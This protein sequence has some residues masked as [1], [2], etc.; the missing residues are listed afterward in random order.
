MHPYV[1]ERTEL[2]RNTQYP[3]SVV[4]WA[5]HAAGDP[6]T[7][8]EFAGCAAMPPVTSFANAHPVLFCLTQLC[9]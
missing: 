1:R 8:R 2:P 6:D 3:P 4:S 5:R 9:S 7:R